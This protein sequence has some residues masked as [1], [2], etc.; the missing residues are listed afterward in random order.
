MACVYEKTEPLSI[1]TAG[2]VL[3]TALEL[4]PEEIICLLEG[5]LL[6]NRRSGSVEYNNQYNS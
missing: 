4:I 6:F 2:S 1:Q 5:A 3:G